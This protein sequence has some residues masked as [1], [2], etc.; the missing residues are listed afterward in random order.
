M[1]ASSDKSTQVL[2]LP[3]LAH[4]RFCMLRIESSQSKRKRVLESAEPERGS[5]VVQ[6]VI[7]GGKLARTKGP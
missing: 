7:I 1:P 4:P 6:Y 5:P 2:V 3:V